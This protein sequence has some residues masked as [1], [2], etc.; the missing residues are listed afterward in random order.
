MEKTPG[1]AKDS[2][3]VMHRWFCYR[4]EKLRRKDVH[5]SSAV[6]ATLLREAAKS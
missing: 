5:C 4:I 2:D 3:V 1:Q 6:I